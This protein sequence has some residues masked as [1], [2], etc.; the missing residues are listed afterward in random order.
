M[1][2]FEREDPGYL[3]DQLLTYLGNKRSLLPLI[4]RAAAHV[5]DRI[6]RPLVALDAFSGSGAVSRLLKSRCTEVIANDLE[7]YARVMSECHLANRSDVDLDRIRCLAEEFNSLVNGGHRVGGFIEEL[8]A[9]RDDDAIQ[10]GE[11]VFYTHD[12]AR[13]LDAYATLI[14]RLDDDVR[15]FLLAPLLSAASVHA[16]TSGVFKG[17]HKDRAT[18]IGQFGG[19]GRQALSRILRTVEL[20][21]PILSRHTTTHRVLQMDATELP[22][23]LGHVDVAY[24]DPPY[25]EHPYGSNYFMLNLI[26]DHRRPE[27]IS[28]VSGIPVDW[29]RSDYNTRRRS[30]QLMRDLV[31]DLDASFLIVSF[32]DEGHIHPD[33]MADMLRAVGTVTEFQER[34]NTF[35]GSR[36]LGD[37]RLHVTEHLFVVEKC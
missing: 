33:D 18:G 3:T 37:R 25:N 9:P 36:N 23:H 32:N 26:A 19:S 2:T 31:R 24:L 34:H 28:A 4:D 14:H 10:H 29:Q 20:S 21:A 30:P 12:N 22:A 16:N 6:G 35:R 27:R 8:Y 15:P 17:F 13:R 1:T 11:R 5:Q 7:S